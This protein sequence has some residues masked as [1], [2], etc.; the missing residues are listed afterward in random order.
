M[1]NIINFFNTPSKI[2]NKDS[3]YEQRYFCNEN[4]V[5]HGNVG[6][7]LNCKHC[8]PKGVSYQEV[9]YCFN[10]NPTIEKEN[11]KQ[12]TLKFSDRITL[13]INKDKSPVLKTFNDWLK[14]TIEN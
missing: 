2:W 5:I 8:N 3:E 7:T 4:K 10:N 1:E 14:W 6:E 12:Y 9:R 11:D 13:K